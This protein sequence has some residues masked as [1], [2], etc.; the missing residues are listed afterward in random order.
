[1]KKNKRVQLPVWTTF[2]PTFKKMIMMNN[3]LFTQIW[4][5]VL[6]LHGRVVGNVFQPV[7]ENLRSLDEEGPAINAKTLR[8]VHAVSEKN[9]NHV[10]RRK[11]PLHMRGGVPVL[12]AIGRV[13]GLFAQK[14]VPPGM[15]RTN[16][17]FVLGRFTR[18]D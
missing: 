3:I 1:M 17:N 18:D 2:S 10:F 13:M 6:V 8:L 11:T 9:K 4:L 12:M 14:P 15:I 5:F 16:R 7:D